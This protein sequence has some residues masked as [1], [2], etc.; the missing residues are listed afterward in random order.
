VVL[1]GNGDAGRVCKDGDPTRILDDGGPVARIGFGRPAIARPHAHGRRA[2]RHRRF[3]HALE[4]QA[5]RFAD[6]DT[7]V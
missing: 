4:G 7:I 6:P 3:Q 2:E 1:E 5:V